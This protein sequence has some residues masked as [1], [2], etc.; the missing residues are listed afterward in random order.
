LIYFKKNMRAITL[1]EKEEIWAAK[2]AW[3]HQNKDRQL[4]RCNSLSD[5]ITL[6]DISNLGNEIL[7]RKK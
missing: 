6:I 7:R 1:E 4:Y 3:K 2:K 5:I